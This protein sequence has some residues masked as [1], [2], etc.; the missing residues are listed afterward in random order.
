MTKLTNS[1]DWKIDGKWKRH[2]EKKKSEK[3]KK[4]YIYIKH[5]DWITFNIKSI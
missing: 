5:E 3:L 1:R 4:T 2:W